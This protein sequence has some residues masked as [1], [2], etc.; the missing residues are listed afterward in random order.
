MRERARP[1]RGPA[2]RDRRRRPALARRPLADQALALVGARDD[3]RRPADADPARDRGDGLRGHVDDRRDRATPT[4]S[5]SCACSTSGCCRAPPTCPRC[6]STRRTGGS[7]RSGCGRGQLVMHP[8]PMNRG[9]EIDPRVADSAVVA[10]HR[11]GALRPRRA[12]GR[13][14]RPARRRPRRRRAAGPGGRMTLFWPERP[15]RQPRRS[16][17][18]AC[19]TR[20]AGSTAPTTSRSRTA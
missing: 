8:G 18:R 3:A 14:L 4:S 5:T 2:R 11:P 15:G 12:D 19:S 6:A 17:A 20:R 9:V 16:A 13:A 7:R 10:D 1:A